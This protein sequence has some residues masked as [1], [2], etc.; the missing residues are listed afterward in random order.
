MASLAPADLQDQLTAELKQLIVRRVRIGLSII[1]AGVVLFAI[2]DH[3]LMADAP[4]WT[5]G[6]N[7][8]AAGLVATAFWLLGHPAIQNRPVPFALLIVALT[9][10]L[11]ALAGIWFGDIAPT[12]ILCVVVAL[13]AG[14]TLPWGIW[15][16]LVSVAIAGSAIA[17]NASLVVDHAD[18]PAHLA[19]AVVTALAVSVVLSFELQRNRLRFIEENLQRRRAEDDLALLNAELELRIGERTAQLAAAKQR[20][21]REALERLQAT[22]EL[23]GSEKRLQDILD[24]ATATIYLKDIAGRYLLVNRHWEKAFGIQRKDVVGKTVHDVHPAEIAD[25]LRVNDRKVLVVRA[26]LQIE[27]TLLQRGELRTY[28]S[29]KFPLFDSDSVL[30]GVC[31]ISTDITA[32]KQAEAE[33]RRSEAALSALVENTTDAIWSIDRNYDVT[34]FNSVARQRFRDRF[35]GS[36]DAAS[37]VTCTPPGIWEGLRALYDRALAGEHVQ[38]ES[39]FEA[40]DGVS[41]VLLSVHPL[42]DNGT[43]T[44]ATVFSKEITEQQAGRGPG[45]PTPGRAGARAAPQHHGRDGGGAGAR[46]QPAAGRD[47][48]LRAGRR[49]APA[50][51]TTD[52]AAT[53]ADRR[54]HRRRGAARRRDHPPAARLVRK[55]TPQQEQVD[56]NAL[57]RKSAQLIQPEAREQ[58]IAVHLELA[59]DL[60]RCTAT[61]SRS[62][63]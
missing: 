46:D 57:A 27:E 21:E 40:G 7:V 34:V 30:V 60:P 4:R 28:V 45:A 50:R 17:V 13:T 18:R 33:L 37:F 43:V 35:G 20:L 16:Q 49:A 58:G 19:A 29:V 32:Q 51:R 1:V 54:R 10:S 23:R 8:L 62:S 26:P 53:P 47:R 11:R 14:V 24:N 36:F 2:A 63:R 12:A 6:V 41:H 38:I 56:L 22:Q 55:E 5:D 44:G 48:Q 52:V 25:A 61:A 31:G 15:P 39:A 3:L 9:C 42:V 59:P